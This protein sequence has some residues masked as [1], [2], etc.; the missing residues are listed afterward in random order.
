MEE[1][2][3]NA[4]EGAELPIISTDANSAEVTSEIVNSVTGISNAILSIFS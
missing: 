1:V 3:E 4:A 2:R